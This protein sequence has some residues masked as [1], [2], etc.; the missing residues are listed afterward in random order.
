VPKGSWITTLVMQTQSISSKHST[1]PVISITIPFAYEPS[2]DRS[3]AGSC[4]WLIKTQPRGVLLILWVA[5]CVGSITVHDVDVVGVKATAMAIGHWQTQNHSFYPSLKI[6]T[7]CKRCTR[8]YLMK[9]FEQIR[10]IMTSPHDN[11]SCLLLVQ[12]TGSIQVH[13]SP[14][15]VILF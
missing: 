8:K 4:C 13:F 12:G 14:P 6:S 9:K 1:N 7:S 10:N 3:F 2:T 5:N 11:R 15:N